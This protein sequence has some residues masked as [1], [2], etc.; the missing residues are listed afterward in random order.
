MAKKTVVNAAFVEKFVQ[1]NGFPE[2]GHFSDKKDLQ[3]FYKF[4]ST[5]QLAEWV[6]LEG[7]EYVPND[8]A[9]IH[10]M[11][12]CMAVLYKHFPKAPA[13]KK[14]SK[15]AQYSLEDLINMALENSVA[16]EPTEDE[17]ILRMRAIMALKAA[18]LVE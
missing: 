8:S 6:E 15:Y 2:V 17:R 10:R 14:V 12:L 13:A 9:P 11:R 3:K 1:E 18:G 4:L 5:E 16:F 7:L